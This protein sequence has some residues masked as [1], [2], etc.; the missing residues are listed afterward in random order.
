MTDDLFVVIHGNTVFPGGR[1]GY[2]RNSAVV[3]AYFEHVTAAERTVFGHPRFTP[4]SA[5]CLVALSGDINMMPLEWFGPALEADEYVVFGSTYLK[6]P[7]CDFLVTRRAYNI[8]MGCSPWYRGAS[9]NFWA[10]YDGRPDLVGAT[11][12]L[13]SKGL[14][15]G[16]ILFHALPAAVPADPF[17]LGMLAVQA[18]QW[19]LVSRLK[20]GS[21]RRMAT[22]AQDRG[23]EIRYT[24]GSDF[25]DDVARAYLDRLPS[26]DAIGKRLVARDLSMFSAPFIGPAEP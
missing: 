21:I 19:G 15:S 7:L 17:L 25:T 14:D 26:P 6:G 20:D 24:R 16:P 22:I 23:K 8:H 1:P 18:A 11:I 9:C 3:G 13:L 10:Q 5:R 4:K 2:Y 12:H